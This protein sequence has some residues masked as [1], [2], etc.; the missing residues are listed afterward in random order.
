[1]KSPRIRCIELTTPATS[2]LRRPDTSPMTE[3]VFFR[4]YETLEPA[5]LKGPT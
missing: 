3:Q 5:T 1:M 2:A 4:L